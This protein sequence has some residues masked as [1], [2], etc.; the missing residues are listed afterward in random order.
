[1]SCPTPTSPLWR[2]PDGSPLSCVEKIKVMNENLVELR[3]LAQ[4]MLEDALLMGCSEGQVRDVLHQLVDQLV[5]A[6]PERQ[7]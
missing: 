5:S 1:M 6:Y 3:Q 4:D 2:K 7:D